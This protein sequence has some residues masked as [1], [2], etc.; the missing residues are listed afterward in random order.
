MPKIDRLKKRHLL[1]KRDRRA[2][3]EQIETGLGVSVENLDDRANLEEG[4]LD[5]GTTVLLLDG[6]IIF[7]ELEKRL[8]PT[9][10]ALLE[11]YIRVPHITVDMGAVKYV[12]N[13]AD[14]MR[15]GVT[16]IDDGIEASAEAWEKRWISRWPCGAIQVSAGW[17]S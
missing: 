10:Y 3:L 8:V 6:S 16:K 9:L 7:F 13:G 17:G 11:G 2:R 14:I 12:V 5:E 1:K 4:L 15:P